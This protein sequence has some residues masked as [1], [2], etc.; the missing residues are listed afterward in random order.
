MI[1]D[2]LTYKKMSYIIG[3]T[4]VII[5]SL[6]YNNILATQEYDNENVSPK[7]N[8]GVNNNKDPT[9]QM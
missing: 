5:T 1:E 7:N 6:H 3:S 9:I 4:I 8:K 2:D